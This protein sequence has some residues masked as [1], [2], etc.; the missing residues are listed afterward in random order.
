VSGE[1]VGICSC[2]RHLDSGG[3]RRRPVICDLDRLAAHRKS[4]EPKRTGQAVRKI[5][6][7]RGE[8]TVRCEIH[9]KWIV[10]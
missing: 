1:L 4:T 9:A 7:F 2:G 6:Y 10:R 5:G 3:I 8:M